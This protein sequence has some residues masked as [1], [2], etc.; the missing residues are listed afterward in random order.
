MVY[1]DEP[2][3]E[4]PAAPWLAVLIPTYNGAAY[5]PKALDSL[6]V[7]GEPRMEIIAI[8]DGSTDTTLDILRSNRAR[9]PLR[10]LEREHGDNWVA[11]TNEAMWASRGEFVSILHQD[12][13]WH[14]NRLAVLRQVLAQ[15]PD[16]AMLV[17]SVTFI[18]AHG[19]KVGTWRCPLP[20][21]PRI[22]P[23]ERAFE[24]L[25]VQNFIAAPAP[26]FSRAAAEAAG[27]L[28]ESLWYLADWDLWLKLARS[29]EIVYCPQP[30]ASFRLHAASQTVVRS[31]EAEELKRQHAIV[32]ARHLAPLSLDN[33]RHRTI[34]RAARF[35]ADMNI[36]LA[37]MW[38]HGN[39]TQRTAR[40]AA[41]LGR[42]LSLGPGGMCAYLR[43]SRI[44]ERVS[45]RMR[46]RIFA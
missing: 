20:S 3:R 14:P 23:C 5:L 10:I 43:Y 29:G 26:L 33:G 12:D 31:G 11:R 22:L 24:R 6:L 42:F 46:S 18:N 36:L 39:R 25:L 9:L 2:V 17:H 34:T 8:D 32:H 15:H 27:W 45:A 16:A 1:V 41:M 38:G 7:Q 4:S 44:F 13:V 35:S 28:D 19:L 40:I 37:G 21:A 30:L